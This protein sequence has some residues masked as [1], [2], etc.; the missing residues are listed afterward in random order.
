MGAV[1]SR[2]LRVVQRIE[3]R[4]SAIL[5]T[6]LTMEDRMSAEYDDLKREVAETRQAIERAIERLGTLAEEIRANKDDPAQLEA[7]ANDLDEQQSLLE[8][9]ISAGSSTSS[10]ASGA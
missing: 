2:I 6:L 3:M 10:A 8:G 5:S 1:I 7:L 9:A 4:L